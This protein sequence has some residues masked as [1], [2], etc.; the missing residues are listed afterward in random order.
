MEGEPPS[1]AVMPVHSMLACLDLGESRV[2]VSHVSDFPAQFGA[3]TK[4]ITTVVPIQYI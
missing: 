3:K 1:V 4:K 2:G